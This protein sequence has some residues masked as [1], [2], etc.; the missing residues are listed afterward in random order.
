MV[1]YKDMAAKSSPRMKGDTSR[2]TSVLVSQAVGNLLCEV[3]CVRC[4]VSGVCGGCYG[5]ASCVTCCGV[6]QHTVDK[7]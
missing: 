2:Q 5:L 3:C 4:A 1:A 7:V 6:G